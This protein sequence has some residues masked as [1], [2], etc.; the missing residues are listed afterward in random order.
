MKTS[1]GTLEAEQQRDLFLESRNVF[2]SVG[3]TTPPPNNHLLTVQVKETRRPGAE[4]KDPVA[5][6]T[7]M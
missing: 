2:F 1:L 6:P 4:R 3:D 7:S 5:V